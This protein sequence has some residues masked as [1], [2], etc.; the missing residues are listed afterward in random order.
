MGR[1]KG[2]DVS[3][4]KLGRPGGGTLG[5]GAAG[6]LEGVGT[7]RAAR[8]GVLDAI[9]ATG[10][11]TGRDAARGRD[12][13]AF[14]LDATRGVL[15]GGVSAAEARDVRFDAA[16]GVERE[17]VRAT[18]AAVRAGRAIGVSRQTA[19]RRGIFHEMLRA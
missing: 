10:V 12:A 3:R 13:G 1:A 18:R 14:T 19:R 9:R 17:G 4:P 2:D 6:G 8:A 11:A 7:G 16:A 15:G 5:V